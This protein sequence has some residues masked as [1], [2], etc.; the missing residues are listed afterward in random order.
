MWCKGGCM[1]E[2]EDVDIHAVTATVF[3]SRSA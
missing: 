1:D 3:V 2:A